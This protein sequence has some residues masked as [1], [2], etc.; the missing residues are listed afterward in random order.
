MYTP[1]SDARAYILANRKN[2][3]ILLPTSAHVA[4]GDVVAVSTHAKANTIK[5]E[6]AFNVRIIRHARNKG[7]HVHDDPDTEEAHLGK[8][9]LSMGELYPYF[10]PE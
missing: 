4:P 3:V 10:K 5:P 6:Y 7:G 9:R 1:A 8:V 2:T